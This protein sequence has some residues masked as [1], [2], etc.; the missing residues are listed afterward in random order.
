MADNSFHVIGQDIKVTCENGVLAI[1]AQRKDGSRKAP[2]K[3]EEGS[4]STS[5]A[6][7]D[8]APGTTAASAGSSDSGLSSRLV[9]EVAYG[10][11]QRSFKLPPNTDAER[12]EAAMDKGVLTITL[13][14]TEPPKEKVIQIKDEV[15]VKAA[16][17]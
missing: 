15:A 3:P 10:T 5:A 2:A 7:S 4:S 12:I 11:F 16:A 17:A 6:T 9:S 8:V 1:Q 14:K 13:P